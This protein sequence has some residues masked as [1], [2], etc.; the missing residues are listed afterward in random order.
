M[1]WT[2]G[3]IRPFH[4]DV[5]PASEDLG[6]KGSNNGILL[7]G[8]KGVISC[9]VYGVNPKCYRKGEE[10]LTMP[11]EFD[12]GNKYIDYPEL[13]H[14]KAW[15]EACKAGFG[16]EEHKNL[17]SSFDY[18]GPLTETVLMG[19]L[20]IR[21]YSLAKARADGGRDYYGRRKLL[22]DG[23]NMKITNFEDA[24]QFVSRE[25]REG[26]KLI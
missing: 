26:W 4:P 25:Y 11:E 18:S 2:D 6:G 16:S 24:N 9:D 5:I 19:N 15:T 14:Q 7:I 21:S 20:A 3:G 10:V 17:T 13:G 1:I 23:E 22:W 12:G 8:E